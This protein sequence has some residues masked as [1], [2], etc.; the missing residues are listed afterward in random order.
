LFE[1]LAPLTFALAGALFFAA[2]LVAATL[3]GGAP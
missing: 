1:R 2:G 3:I